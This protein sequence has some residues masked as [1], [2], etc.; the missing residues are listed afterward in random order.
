MKILHLSMSALALT[1]AACGGGG[2]NSSTAAIVEVC[3][4]EMDVPSGLC[5]CVGEESKELSATERRFV[6]ASLKQ[7]AQETARLRSELGFTELTR[8]GMFVMTATQNCAATLPQ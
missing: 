4:A 3:E 2:G 8:A 6:V 1:L 7:D 5:D